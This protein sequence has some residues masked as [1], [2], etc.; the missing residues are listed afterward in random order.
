MSKL[1]DFSLNKQKQQSKVKQG[2]APTLNDKTP[3]DKNT[4]SY[5]LWSSLSKRAGNSILFD[6]PT[7]MGGK[8][9]SYKDITMCKPW[10]TYR[11]FR[12][13]FDKNFYQLGDEQ[14]E[15]DKDILNPDNKCY[16]PQYCMFVPKYINGLFT[17]INGLNGLPPGVSI[18]DNKYRSRVNFKGKEI[19][20]GT[21]SD[22]DSAFLAYKQKKE[23]IIKQVADEYIEKYGDAF[24]EK[25]YNAMYKYEVRNNNK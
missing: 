8:N 4:K 21:F 24:P 15:I 14:M 2:R 7:S 12:V 6:L 11:N 23:E 17:S 25:L 1:G 9:Q 19:H 13:W 3:I 22:I 10:H 18:K 20:L 16:S 5:K